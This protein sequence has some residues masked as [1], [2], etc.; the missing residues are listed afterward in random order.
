MDVA[1]KVLTAWYE[2]NAGVFCEIM[3][4]LRIRD[5]RAWIATYAK[6]MEYHRVKLADRDPLSADHGLPLTLPAQLNTISQ[7]EAY[8]LWRGT[9]DPH[10]RPSP[11]LLS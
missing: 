7:E 2:E 10:W 5:P 3:E 8:E 11:K 1:N 9:I 6:L 4:D